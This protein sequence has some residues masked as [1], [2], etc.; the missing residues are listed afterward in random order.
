MNDKQVRERV[1]A[2]SRG[3]PAGLRRLKLHYIGLALALGAAAVV[4]S[5]PS[6]E[7]VAAPVSGFVQEVYAAGFT[8]P[9]DLEWAPNGLLFVAE[10]SGTIKVVSGTT[11]TT[12]LD[13]SDEVNAAGERGLLGVT[14]H[15]DFV[16][17]SPYVYALYAYDAPEAASGSG[18]AARDGSGQRVAR[19]SRFTA[20][21]ATGYITAVPGSETTILGAAGTWAAIGDPTAQDG[22]SSPA[23]SCGQPGTYVDNCIPAD[24]VHHTAGMVRF[25]SDG[26]LYVGS[27]DGASFDAEDRSLRSLDVDSLA[28]KIMRI[29]PNT[30]LGLSD[31]PFWDGDADS[32]ASRVY[33]LGLRNPYRFTQDAAGTMYIGDVGSGD[34]EEI[35]SAP[36]GA[37]F[38]W[39]CY[40]GGASGSLSQNDDFVTHADCQAYYLGNSATAPLYS[41]NHGPGSAAIIAGEV[42]EGSQW[43]VEFH[44]S[45]IIGDYVRATLSGIDVASPAPSATDLATSTV[46]VAM[47]FGPD[48]HLYLASITTG[49]IDR[50][51]YAPGEIAA[52][53]VRTTTNPPVPSMISLDGVDRT[54]WGLDWLAVS[55]ADYQQCF[56]DVP[57]WVTPP[58]EL[59]SVASGVTTVS[60]G[61]F[62][63]KATLTVTTRVEGTVDSPLPSVIT[64]DGAPSGHWGLMAE[65]APG[66]VDIC[67]GA[68]A[69]FLPPPCQTV[70]LS[71]GGATAVEGVFA[72]TPGATAPAPTGLLRVATTPAVPSTIE[73][74]GIETGQ[75]GMPWIAHPAGSYLVC[76]SDVPG[77]VTPPCQNADVVTGQTTTVDGAFVAMGSVQVATSPATNVVVSVDGIPRNQWGLFTSIEAGDQNV[78]AH[79]LSGDVCGIASV[80]AAANTALVLSP[81]GPPVNLPPTADAGPD[82]NAVDTDDNGSHFVTLGGTGSSDPD[83]VITSWE[84]RDGATLIASG[85]GQIVSLPVGSHSIELTVTDDGGASATDVVA[86]TIDPAPNDPP[87][88][89]AG[90]DQTVVDTDDNGSQFV[91]LDGTGSSDNDGVISTWEWRE[92]PTLIATG[93]TPIVNFVVGGHTVELTVTDDDGATATDTVLITVDPAPN[94]PPIANAGPDQTVVDTDDNGSGDVTLDGALSSDNDGVIVSWEWRNGPILIAV[95][96]TPA[97]ALTVGTHTLELTVTDDDGAT[98][99]D[100]VEITVEPPD[101]ILYIS[102]ANAGT[103]GGVTFGEEDVIAFDTGTSTWSMYFDGSDVD[104]PGDGGR[105]IDAVHVMDDG[106][107]LLSTVR[108]GELPGVGEFTE[109]DVLRFVPTSTGATTAGTFEMYIDGSDVELTAQGEN[110]D[111]I[112]LLAGGDLLVS[113]TEQPTVSGVVGETANDLLLLDVTSTGTTSAGTWSMYFDASDIG[114]ADQAEQIDGAWVAIDGSIHVTTLGNFAA[115]G[116][117]GTADDVLLCDPS[118]T[119]TL[120]SCAAISLFWDASIDGIDGD[121]VDAFS[122]GY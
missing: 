8:I 30:G 84:W 9:V 107:L 83:G 100:S 118:S 45:L 56:G 57:G 53:F 12:F 15:P 115:G 122:V 20:D 90:P 47:E 40:E 108:D 59:I 29:D 14:V 76:F 69:N 110:V 112:H 10:K 73:V 5:P 4:T 87:V 25:G 52:G 113:T 60:E 70:A 64:I 54:Q 101:P 42:Y 119:G 78:C 81:G 21:V 35:N 88:A 44:G 33:Y 50:I 65:L 39:P 102:T 3:V 67:F 7:A 26:M 111:A 38:G 22:D 27:G 43:P 120:T 19:L 46:P 13:L 2:H 18:N 51:R 48:G 62:V 1:S 121:D 68:V 49:S 82:Q 6:D 93:S 99:T 80:A 91:T 74:N 104:I 36:P 72:D 55:P 105:D 106:S 61:S 96:Q 31:N 85:V 97:A 116:V 86:I 95:G 23:W 16:S 32:N 11:T 37:D 114:L 103:V 75:F 89:H 63:R 71:A 117:N 41:Y 17:G 77:F 34:W 98:A 79:F 109:N 58:C 24:S 92:G 28:G 94:D 66:L